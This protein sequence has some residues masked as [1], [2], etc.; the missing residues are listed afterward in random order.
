MIEICYKI[1]LKNELQRSHNIR[2]TKLFL[3]QPDVV[4]ELCGFSFIMRE[5]LLNGRKQ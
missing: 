5:I 3:F 1:V 4:V 2:V